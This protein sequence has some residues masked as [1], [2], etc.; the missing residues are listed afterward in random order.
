MPDK[1]IKLPVNVPIKT[2]P[3]KIFKESHNKKN[4]NQIS[5]KVAHLI[6]YIEAGVEPILKKAY[7]S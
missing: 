1:K 3:D 2:V 7:V 6:T 4:L 5:S